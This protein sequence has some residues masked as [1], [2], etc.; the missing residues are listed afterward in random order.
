MK[1]R[2]VYS[3]LCVHAY[4]VS[5]IYVHIFLHQSGR[6]YMCISLLYCIMDI[7]F[8]LFFIN[9]DGVQ[10]LRAVHSSGETLTFAAAAWATEATEW[11]VV[12]Y[13]HMH[14]YIY[15]RIHKLIQRIRI[16]TYTY[17]PMRIYIVI[18]HELIQHIHIHT[19][20]HIHL[21]T[22]THVH[23]CSHIHT[24]TGFLLLAYWKNMT[25]Y[26]RLSIGL[27]IKKGARSN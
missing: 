21:H 16:H 2:Y 7:C 3:S 12:A 4:F 26:C 15:R 1:V 8:S 14:I 19:R 11:C 6:I 27:N 17:T 20:T 9:T 24:Y 23:I 13:T 10:M 25:Q 18:H 22:Y 5:L